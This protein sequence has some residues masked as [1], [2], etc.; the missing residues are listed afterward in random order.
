MSASHNIY[1]HDKSAHDETSYSLSLKCIT[2][3]FLEACDSLGGEEVIVSLRIALDD[4]GIVFGKRF[5]TENLRF[6][7]D[8]F[9]W[10][11]I[12]Q[13]LTKIFF[14]SKF[15]KLKLISFLDLK[16]LI[17][18]LNNNDQYS[19]NNSIYISEEIKSKK[20]TCIF[21]VNSKYNH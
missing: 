3:L 4:N 10:T 18:S 17:V 15:S 14:S 1:D 11:D 20:R 5:S 12:K 9:H 6:V 8:T 16:I 2:G 19:K 21:F 7:I 13:S